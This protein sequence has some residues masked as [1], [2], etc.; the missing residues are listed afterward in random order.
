MLE[1]IGRLDGRGGVEHA[2][3]L[4]HG[5]PA[6][7]VLLQ[8]NGRSAPCPALLARKA[9][10]VRA[11]RV[12]DGARRR[13]H[14]LEAPEGEPHAQVLLGD[15]HALPKGAKALLMVVREERVAY[16]RG[17]LPK[18]VHLGSNERL[19][20][21]HVEG[22]ERLEH[23]G[24]AVAQEEARHPEL[25]VAGR[26]VAH[27]EDHLHKELGRE[28]HRSWDVGQ[29]RQVAPAQLLVLDAHGV[30]E[31]HELHGLERPQARQLLGHHLVR[32]QLGLL[33]A[34]GLDAVHKVGRAGEQRRHEPPHVAKEALACGRGHAPGLAPLDPRR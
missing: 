10:T 31:P 19:E 15:A 3:V 30:A 32:E 11:H 23:L 12:L 20:D 13:D 8:P 34:V 33:H 17:G 22:L 21:R 7:Q 27:L 9:H 25:V 4:A 16:A 5:H 2:K 18:R 14:P 6:A 1:P 28:Q 29:P 26:R 24:R